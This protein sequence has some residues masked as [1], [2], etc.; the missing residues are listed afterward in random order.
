[1]AFP[2]YLVTLALGSCSTVDKKEITCATALTIFGITILE[3]LVHNIVNASTAISFDL[4]DTRGRT[5]LAVEEALPASKSTNKSAREA[6]ISWF[7]SSFVPDFETFLRVFLRGLSVV[8]SRTS[9]TRA[10]I[11]FKILTRVYS[12]P[13]A[14]NEGADNSERFCTNNFINEKTESFCEGK[15]AA[16]FLTH[17]AIIVIACNLFELVSSSES[18]D[19]SIESLVISLN[20]VRSSSC[21][22]VSPSNECCASPLPPKTCNSINPRLID[23]LVSV[24]SLG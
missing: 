17:S 2:L 5:L 16:R 12:E 15:D 20:K 1:M 4:V 24:S 8:S 23:F 18:S 14:L 11:V 6:Y 19:I 21:D 22:V 10:R 3:A 9:F 7:S 13:S